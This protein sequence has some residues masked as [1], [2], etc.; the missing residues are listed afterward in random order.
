MLPALLP[1]QSLAVLGQG[2]ERAAP[3]QLTL[4]HPTFAELT[5]VLLS[6]ACHCLL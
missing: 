6:A 5:F 2:R 4:P 1:G 3:V